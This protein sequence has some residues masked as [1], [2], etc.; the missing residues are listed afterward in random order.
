MFRKKKYDGA[1]A[2]YRLA[3]YALERISTLAERVRKLEPKKVPQYGVPGWPYPAFGFHANGY[4]SRLAATEAALVERTKERDAARLELDLPR[5]RIDSGAA[6]NK[7][8]AAE[9][10]NT[11]LKRDLAKAAY[12][13][14]EVAKDLG[15]ARDKLAALSEELVNTK[16][17][18]SY[19]K[20]VLREARGSRDD[21]EKRN[22]S[23]I[24]EN[25]ALLGI[26]NWPH[27]ITSA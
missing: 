3:E 15:F 4:S 20:D 16:A 17:A 12:L 14:G 19:T 13:A 6:L 24:A 22:A 1:A 9:A 21:A 2:S 7:L 27:R 25:A 5:W 26:L 10:K 23:L 11:E 8:A 18:L